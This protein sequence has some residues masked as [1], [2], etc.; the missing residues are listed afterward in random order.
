MEFPLSGAKNAIPEFTPA[1]VPSSGNR[2]ATVAERELIP[3]FNLSFD[4]LCIAD[5]AGFFRRINPAFEKTLGYKRY[6]L[7]LRPFTDF[8]HKDD[9]VETAKQLRNIA[10][11]EQQVSFENRFRC[12]DG[13]FKWLSW[14]AT[15]IKDAST[16]GNVMYAV[17]REITYEKE[18][19]RMK[20][21]FI[22]LAAHQLRTP[23]TS[24]KWFGEL[25]ISGGA[26][27]L[28]PEQKEM[29]SNM[30]GSTERMVALV[31]SLLNISRIESGRL[32]VEP[33]PSALSDVIS[34]VV[35]DVKAKIEEKQHYLEV[36]VA[37]DLPQ[38]N[39]DPKLVRNVYMNLLTNAIKYTPKGGKVYI[40]VKVLEE[41]SE[42]SKKADLVGKGAIGGEVVS[43]IQDSGMGIPQSQQTKVF[44]K[45]FRANNA[46]MVE[47]DGNG[48]GLYLVKSI[49]EE[50]GGRIWFESEENKGTKFYF[51]L[52]LAGSAAKQGEVRLG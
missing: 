26:G 3:F 14:K 15:S 21:E 19:D 18:V 20:T 5:T 35:F 44:E 4:M 49:V 34:G 22:S 28:S 32:I 48:L 7:M 10:I 39:I 23:L 47:T 1:P 38:L 40:E 50:S 41:G 37:K 27:E 51:T 43:M 2:Q 36:S 8:V 45:F 13:S 12:A 6:E 42:L 29:V 46:V 17:V 11:G 30:Y 16:K 31:N 9:L 25:L 52:P 24:I 33:K